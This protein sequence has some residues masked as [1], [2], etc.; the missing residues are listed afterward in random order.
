[1]R[2]FDLTTMA[3]LAVLVVGAGGARAEGIWS[4]WHAFCGSATA[5]VFD[6]GPPLHADG[7]L[8]DPS[9]PFAD[10]ALSDFTQPGSMGAG[11]SASTRSSVYA[12]VDQ[13]SVSVRLSAGYSPSVFPG[14]DNP[15]GEADAELSSVIE[16]TMPV[17][18]LDWDH[19]LRL[20]EDAPFF[21]G[22]TLIT[23]ENVTQSQTLLTLTENTNIVF[24]TLQG[25]AGDLIRITSDISGAGSMGPGSR[26]E[27]VSRVTMLFVPEPHAW[28]LLAIAIPLIRRRT[29]NA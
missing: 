12:F 22:S 27:Y 15:G 7:C 21:E 26:K 8:A 16:F 4:P 6:G 3:G 17:D 29:R 25:A 18:E 14:G 11:A 5:N 2:H 13:L 10:V 23:V 1:M 28:M 20:I 24:T 19:G 9:E